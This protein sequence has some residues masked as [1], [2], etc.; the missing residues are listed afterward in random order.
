MVIRAV[1]AAAGT[2][3]AHFHLL[4]LF[5]LQAVARSR[6]TMT[7]LLTRPRFKHHFLFCGKMLGISRLA[8]FI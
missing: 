4:F 5:G 8:S 2:A 7:G 3:S 1:D 6:I